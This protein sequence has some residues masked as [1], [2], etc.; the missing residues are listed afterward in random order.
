MVTEHHGIKEEPQQTHSAAVRE[1]ARHKSVLRNHHMQ[2]GNF[3]HN[4]NWLY[5][6]VLLS[7]M[8]DLYLYYNQYAQQ[9]V[10]ESIAVWE[11]L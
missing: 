2:H 8:L 4:H 3:E 10:Y 11:I 5:Q 6:M 9:I 7:A 1:V